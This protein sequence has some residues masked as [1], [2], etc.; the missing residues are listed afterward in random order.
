MERSKAGKGDSWVG[1]LKDMVGKI[2]LL[3]T[4]VKEAREQARHTQGSSVPGR[5]NSRCQ[6]LEVGMCLA[7]S[8]HNIETSLGHSSDLENKQVNTSINED[9]KHSNGKNFLEFRRET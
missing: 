8:K 6:G 4:D 5:G 2:S 1:V 9:V 7:Y 3:D